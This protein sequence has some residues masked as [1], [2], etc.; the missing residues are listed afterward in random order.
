MHNPATSVSREE[1]KKA[2][3]TRRKYREDVEAAEAQWE[4]ASRE[5]ADDSKRPPPIPSLPV[6]PDLNQDL[7]CANEP[8]S[9]VRMFC[10]AERRSQTSLSFRPHAKMLPTRPRLGTSHWQVLD[11]PL[12][13]CR[14]PPVVSRTHKQRA[15]YVPSGYRART[16]IPLV[17]DD[18][19][20][21]RTRRT[22]LSR[23]ALLHRMERD[24]QHSWSA[25]R[26]R[27]TATRESTR[28]RKQDMLELA[29]RSGQINALA[30]MSASRQTRRM[31]SWFGKEPTPE[32]AAALAELAKYD[33]LLW[34]QAQQKKKAGKKSSFLNDGDLPED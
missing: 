34:V 22:A 13:P 4:I 14:G 26:E 29:H 23:K 5:C 15:F 10:V 2:F 28:K 33:D 32:E 1:V 17:L 21:Q 8:S 6:P 16:G 12:L 3:A 20:E 25:L 18:L 30:R 11:E 27:A 9:A 19:V 24:R 7:I 31:P